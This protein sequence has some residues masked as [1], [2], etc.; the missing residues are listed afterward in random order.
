MIQRIYTWSKER[1]HNHG[2]LIREVKGKDI[3]ILHT[4]CINLILHLVDAVDGERCFVYVSQIF[5]WLV[6]FRRIVTSSFAL[7]HL[8]FNVLVDTITSDSRNFYFN[9]AKFYSAFLKFFVM[10]LLLKI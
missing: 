2:E 4:G 9:L 10:Q 6:T 8:L 5:A 3:S 1:K 7:T